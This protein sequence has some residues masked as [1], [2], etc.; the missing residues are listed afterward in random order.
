MDYTAVRSGSLKFKGEKKKK[1][2]NKDKSAAAAAVALAEKIEI[3]H[4][5]FW[6]V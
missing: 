5:A 4:N 2:K 3:R 6:L 1:K